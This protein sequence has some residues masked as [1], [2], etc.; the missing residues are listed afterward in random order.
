MPPQLVRDVLSHFRFDEACN[1][2]LW[3]W[4]RVGR[5]GSRPVDAE[6]DAGD[7]SRS[8]GGRVEG[9]RMGWGMPSRSSSPSSSFDAITT[10]NAAPVSAIQ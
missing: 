2:A 3:A 1:I 8:S 4:E 5:M 6:L 10:G 7:V 9:V